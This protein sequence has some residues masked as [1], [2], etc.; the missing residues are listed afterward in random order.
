MLIV[1][2]IYQNNWV[3][4]FACIEIETID[5]DLHYTNMCPSSLGVSLDFEWN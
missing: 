1:M 3:I 4:Q 2:T 5:V